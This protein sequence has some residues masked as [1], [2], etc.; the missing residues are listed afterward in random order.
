METPR[1]SHTEYL[2][3]Y[4]DIPAIL[5]EK[6]YGVEGAK[7]VHSTYLDFT[8]IYGITDVWLLGADYDDILR[9]D[10]KRTIKC[11]EY[12]CYEKSLKESKIYKPGTFI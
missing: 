8:T 3:E 10:A 12:S 4:Q 9:I 6:F 5:S 11:G 2:T 7:S 1:L